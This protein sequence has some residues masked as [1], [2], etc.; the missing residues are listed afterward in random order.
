MSEVKKLRNG[1]IDIVKFLFALIITDFHFNTGLFPGG[2]MAVE[3]FFFISGYFMMQN[4]NRN[5]YPEDSLGASTVRF[6]KGKFETLLP[7]L[8]PA[9]IFAFGIDCYIYQRPLSEMLKQAPLLLFDVVPLF[10][11]GF[12]G[13]Y[14]VGISWYLAAMFISLAILYPFCKNSAAVLF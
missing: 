4:I 12:Q 8:L 5:K 10:E 2:R 6:M 1:Y 3:G 9:V 14:V 11:A 13:I 7:Y